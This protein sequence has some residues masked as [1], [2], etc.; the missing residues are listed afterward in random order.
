MLFFESLRSVRNDFITLSFAASCWLRNPIIFADARCLAWS[1]ALPTNL[2]ALES[3]IVGEPGCP[4]C[5]QVGSDLVAVEHHS[6][7][8]VVVDKH[9]LLHGNAVKAVGDD[10]DDAVEFVKLLCL[11]PVFFDY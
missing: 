8:S 5:F 9:V 11:D 3:S 10:G 1:F 2:E 6:F 7:P 4:P